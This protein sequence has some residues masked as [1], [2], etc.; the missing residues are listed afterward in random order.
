MVPLKPPQLRKGDL[1]GIVSPA[2]PVADVSRIESGVR[3]LEGLGYHVIVGKHVAQTLGYL[4]GTDEERVEDLHAMFRNR[5]VR[6]IIC[7]RGGY[8]TPRLLPLLNYRLIARNPKILAGYSDITALQ[9][10]LWKK[11]RLITFHAPMLGVEMANTIDPWTEEM[12]WSLATSSRRIGSIFVPTDSTPRP[13]HQGKGQGRLLG[14]N[15][16]MV[17][18]ILATPYQPNFTDSV[19]F[20]EDVTE[21]PYRV[22]RMMMQLRNASILSASSAILTGQF[23][24]CVP[25]DKSKPSLTVDEILQESAAATGRP[26]LSNLPFGH[27]PKKM[28]LP[29]GLRVRVNAGQCTI[30]FLESACRSAF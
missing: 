10:A 17:V 24:D 12:F 30:E 15:L 26:F 2:S 25:L 7:V 6:A 21:E 27:I 20:L 18:S 5:E 29:V 14:G 11:C 19:V 16:S 4:A 13:L 1:I 22:D 23:T 28:T 8:G 3:Y 9:L